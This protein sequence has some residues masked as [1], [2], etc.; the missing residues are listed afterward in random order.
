VVDQ[1]LQIGFQTSMAVGGD[2]LP[3][4]VYRDES[5]RSL[6]VAH[7]GT[8]DCSSGNTVTTADSS[9]NVGRGAS[10]AINTS[11][12]PIISYR[13]GIA[14]ALKVL[15]CGN[16]ACTEG[17]Q[18]TVADD[19]G[20]V[21]SK[22]SIMIGSDGLPVISYRDST[23]DALRV[24]HCG[25]ADCS[26][27]NTLELV[28]DPEAD[29][30]DSSLAIGIDGM[31][32]ISFLGANSNELVVVHCEDFTC[33][34]RDDPERIDMTGI[35]G[36]DS[37]IAIGAVGLPVIAYREVSNSDLLVAHCGNIT[38]SLGTL[39]TAVD[40]DPNVAFDISLT[41][42]ADGL[43]I[44]SYADR[45]LNN[46]KFVHCGNARCSNA[47]SVFVIDS[48]SSVIGHTAI[49]VGRD[50]FP[51]IA[52]RDETADALKVAHLSNAFGVPFFRRR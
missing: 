9:G 5:E 37:S 14:G 38:C 26:S 7:C 18:I 44:I 20:S 13:D 39:I 15:S 34:T 51:I 47:N 19:S 36:F 35:N 23:V 17:N 29:G 42:G 21:S 28:D 33:E 6:K 12:F 4:I 25:D 43:P 46:L 48:A 52:Y 49:T 27:G 11:G 41:I 24:T 16:P 45:E 2:G 32:I 3:V 31:P 30:N 8:E 1:G 10:I 22:T 50:G 40:S